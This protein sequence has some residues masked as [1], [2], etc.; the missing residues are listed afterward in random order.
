MAYTCYLHSY[1]R[2]FVVFMFFLQ[3]AYQEEVA[4]PRQVL[5]PL[6]CLSRGHC[7]AETRPRIRSSSQL[8]LKQF[9][10]KKKKQISATCRR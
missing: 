6:P 8:R 10:L 1:S 5:G 3:Q 4:L 2:I 7:R 9:R